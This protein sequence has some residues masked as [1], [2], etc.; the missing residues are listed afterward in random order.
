MSVENVKAFF[1]KMEGDVALQEK[2]GDVNKK[3]RENIDEAIADLVKLASAAG[4]EF[5]ADDYT[6]AR[7][8]KPEDV[9]YAEVTGQ[10]GLPDD[11]PTSWA[12]TKVSNM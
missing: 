6:T 8:H 3:A 12:C 2:M 1:A 9:E 10:R 5:T 11:C 4:F 7:S